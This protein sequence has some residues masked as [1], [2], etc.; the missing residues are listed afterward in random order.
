MAVG[1][2]EVDSTTAVKV[3]VDVPEGVAVVCRFDAEL[4]SHGGLLF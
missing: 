4:V 1:V 2:F 3:D